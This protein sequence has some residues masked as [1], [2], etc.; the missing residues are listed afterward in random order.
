MPVDPPVTNAEHPSSP[1]S[2]LRAARV[3]RSGN[4]GERSENRQLTRRRRGGIRMSG[5]MDPRIRVSSYPRA[6][7]MAM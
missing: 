2:M 3:R 7:S 5:A 4:L 1:N 6:L